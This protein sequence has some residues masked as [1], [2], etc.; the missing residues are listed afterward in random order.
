MAISTYSELKASIADY[1]NR[2]DLTA[3]IPTFVSLAEAQINRDVR[4]WEMENRATTT[5]DS[6]YATRPSEWVET[7]RLSLVSGT[8][9]HMRLISRSAMAE[10]RSNDLN[11]SGT[12]LYYSHSESQYELYPTPDASYTGEVL[13][14]QKIPA[15]SDSATTNWLLSYAPDVYLYGSLI[16][17][18]P[19]LA[20]DGR[21][22]VWASM[23]SAAV[24]QLN[25]R[26]E[27][28]SSSGSGLK[29]RVRGL[30]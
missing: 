19:Y 27:E 20:E 6:H 5:F 17:S 21:T 2:A 10:K 8:T 3:V 30:G 7:I 28:A 24:E 26:S 22:S 13:Y 29:L 1:L 18:A 23:Y 11:A 12:P 25:T 9:T 15:L 14:Y 16:H 4:H